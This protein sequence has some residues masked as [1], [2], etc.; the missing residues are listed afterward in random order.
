MFHIG[1]R[2]DHNT[3]FMFSNSFPKVCCLWKKCKNIVESDRLQTHSKYVNVLFFH[4]TVIT[5]TR[6]SVMLY[7]CCLFCYVHLCTTVSECRSWHSHKQTCSLICLEAEQRF[8]VWSAV[9]N[10]KLFYY[11]LLIHHLKEWVAQANSDVW[12][13]KLAFPSSFEVFAH[14]CYF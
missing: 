4:S 12:G 14:L 1:C 13:V 8:Y 3:H 10:F 2:E 9:L 11:H 5:W 6:L 7:M